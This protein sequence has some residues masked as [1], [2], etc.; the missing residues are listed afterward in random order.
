[1][2]KAHEIAMQ[3]I[4]A[5]RPI[6]EAAMPK[7]KNL[8]CQLRDAATSAAANTAEGGRRIGGDRLHSFR[9]ASGEAAEALSWARIA[10]AWGYVAASTVEPVRAIEDEL[11][12]VLYRLQHPR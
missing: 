6:V 2:F 4:V 7:D 11:Q 10:L 9:I 1:M 3:L 8:A 12:A 5:V